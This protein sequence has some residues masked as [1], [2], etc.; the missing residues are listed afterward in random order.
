MGSLVVRSRELLRRS[1]RAVLG[2]LSVA[3]SV[4]ASVAIFQQHAA[5]T[6][7]VEVP[8]ERM[9]READAIVVGRVERVGVRLVMLPGGGA[10][11]HT[12]TTIRA[13]EWIKGDGCE[14]VRLDEIGGVMEQGGM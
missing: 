3:L 9:V 6:V 11:P 12:I 1:P 2:A 14:R 10:E 8:L 13:V 4:V 7:M 5:A